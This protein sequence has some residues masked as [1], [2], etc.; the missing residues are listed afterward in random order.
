M[1]NEEDTEKWD[2]GDEAAEDDAGWDDD[3]DN[4]EEDWGVTMSTGP[5]HTADM[6][7]EPTTSS[8]AVV[9]LT[10]NEIDAAIGKRVQQLKDQIELDENDCLLLLRKWKW[11]V[12]QV[13]DV[14]FTNSDKIRSE[15]GICLNLQKPKLKSG[16][17]EC[18][19]CMENVDIKI[20]FSLECGHQ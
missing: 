8:Q 3:N 11:S 9:A 10:K 18:Q 16:K 1:S 14:Y 15:A 12:A 17:I 13:M 6:D 19:V 20:V 7:I 4:A 5:T 2:D